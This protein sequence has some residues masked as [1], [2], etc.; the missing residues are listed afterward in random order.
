MRNQSGFTLIEIVM[1]IV[2]M[3]ILSAMAS[4]LAKPVEGYITSIDRADLSDAADTALLR[5]SRDVRQALPNS[6]RI[7]SSGSNTSIDFL[8]ITGGGRYRASPDSL[9]GGDVLN[10]SAA[11]TSFDILGSSVDI[12]AGDQLVVYNLGVPGADAY[13]G[14]TASTHVRRSVSSVGTSLTNVSI[15][16]SAAMPFDSQRHR[17]QIVHEQ[18]RYICDLTAKTLTR[19]AGFTISTPAYAIPPGSSALLATGVTACNFAYTSGSSHRSGL[20]TLN[21]TLSNNSDSVTL[22]NQVHVQNVP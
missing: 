9:G 2:I 22:Q 21:I 8:T 10:F 15:T 1:V 7:N 13:E 17:F 16:S 3:G 20:M 19:Y 11:D 5:I 12:V 6:I 18:V 14:N 4:S